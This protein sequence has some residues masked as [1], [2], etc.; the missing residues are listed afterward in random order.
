M[1]VNELK[2]GVVL[3]YVSQGIHILS[4]LLYT[5]IM[6]RLLGQSEYGLYQFVSSIISYLGLLSFGFGS[7]YIRY[8]SKY[9]VNNDTDGIAKLNGMFMTVFSV[10]G[11]ISLV[12][13]SILVVNTDN[14][15]ASSMTANEI[16]TAKILMGIMVFN[17]AVSF[18]GSVFTSYITANEKYIFQRVIS[19]LSAILNPFLTLPLL[20][21]GFKS[22]SLV[23]VQTVVSMA[24]L[25][26]NIAFCRNKIAIKFD[27][28][29]FDFKLVMELFVFSFW[30]FLNQIIDQIN[31][32]LDK[33]ILGV[34]SGTIAVAVYGVASQLNSLYM[35]LSTAVS[36][37]FAPKINK[38]VAKNN[39]N[40][41][42]TDL[43]ARV[44]RIQFIILM[45]IASGLIVFGRYFI[46]VWA[47]NGYDDSYVIVL[48]LI[49]PCTI[50][51][52]QN[53]GIEIQRAKN[54]HKFRSIIYLVIAIANIA[55]SIPLAKLWGGIGAAMG[56]ALSLLLG[57][58]LIMNIYYHKKI[59]LDII[60]F[61]KQIAKFLPALIAPAILGYCIIRFI[62]YKNIFIFLAL[63]ILYTVVYAA[64]MWL[65]GLNN[66]EKDLILKPL[67]KI[68]P[69]GGKDA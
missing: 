40:G 49:L 43:F 1:K 42:L 35:S 24:S 48:L 62:Q 30:I 27:F 26:A 5:P 20:L 4:G 6:L 23:V 64:S 13:G 28:R 33:F 11:L 52:I 32:S 59:G 63:I 31:W 14:L 16:G 8:Y 7:S 41:L 34:I 61:W 47:G 39:D 36:N 38:L 66:Y 56:T 37:V 58:G 60:Y 15:F 25:C 54:M 68:I 3:S 10:I 69:R 55:L 21:L 18:P 57:N 45:L 53:L 65:F 29:K 46:S 22:I 50:P 2:A 19:V 9:K 12:A 67:N 44:G 17:L 51:L